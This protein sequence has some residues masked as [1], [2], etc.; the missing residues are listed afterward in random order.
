MSPP[1][2]TKPAQTPPLPT[3]VVFLLFHLVYLLLPLLFVVLPIWLCVSDGW[4]HV[5]VT[6]MIGYLS[7][8]AVAHG[9]AKDGEGRPWPAFENWSL[10]ARMFAW[11]PMRLVATKALPPQQQCVFGVHPHGAFAFGRAMF[12][13]CTRQLWD[14]AFGGVDFR[15]LVATAAF[16]VP[17]VREMWL[18]SHCI[19]ASKPAAVRALQKKKSLLL[20]PGGIKEQMMTQRGKHCVCLKNRK[21]FIK[22]ALQHGCSLVPI[23]VF[24]ESDLFHHWSLGRETR[25][26]IADTIGAAVMLAS[27]SLGL[28]PC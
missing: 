20:H 13:F 8:F 26:W 25:V 28:L 19:D 4:C 11:F 2:E 27:G 12:G 10:F 24:G 14:P 6:W 1:A 5:G 21:G 22:L 17:I 3:I 7:W 16:R 9:S 23:C 15:V 18:W